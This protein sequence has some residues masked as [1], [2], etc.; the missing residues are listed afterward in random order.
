[1]PYKIDF[2]DGDALAWTL[3]DDGATV[4]RDPDWTPTFYVHHDDPAV[5]DEIRPHVAALPDVEL[6]IRERHRPGFRHEAEPVLRVD[7]ADLDALHARAHDVWGWREPGELTCWN[8]DFSPEFR[9]CL[10]TD[11]SPVPERDLRTLELERPDGP[12]A[13]TVDALRIGEAI[14]EGEAAVLDH[15]SRRLEREDPDVLFLGSASL[16]PRLYE[17]AQRHDRAAFDLGRGEGDDLPGYQQRAGRSTYESY[18]RTGHSPARYNVPGRVTINAGN[19]FFWDQTNLDGCLDLVERS[20]KPLQELAWA[21]IG[22]VLTAIQ[23][24]EARERDVLVP[25]HSWRHEFFKSARTLHDA[26]RG[27][28]TFAPD[29]GLHEHVHELDFSSLYPNIIVTRNISPETTRCGCCDS[30][31][32]PG[33][34][35]SICEERGYLADVL[36]PI[37]EDRDCIKQELRACDD[38]EH[39]EVLEGRSSALKWILVSCFGYQGFSNAKFG[40]IEC[41][42]SINAFARELL[43]DA[44]ERL[45]QGGWRVVHGI[46]DS[47]WVTPMA[48]R[49]QADL[50][51]LAAAITDDLGIDLEYEAGYDWL[52]FVPRRNDEAGALTKYFGRKRDEDLGAGVDPYKLRGIEARQRSTAPLVEEVQRELIEVLDEK[53]RPEAVCDRLRRWLGRVRRGSVAASDLVLTQRVSKPLEQYQSRTRTVAALQRAERRGLSVPPG[54]SVSYVVADDSKRSHERLR[55]AFEVDEGTPYDQRFYRD[56][57]LRAAESVL[58]PLGWRRADIESYLDDGK[59]VALGAFG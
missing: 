38:P 52:A 3:T 41:H 56:R 33:L 32:V 31:D 9:Y 10:E 21:S 40:R 19:T 50:D 13:P 22:N 5:L 34:G 7:T 28:F 23:I 55:L 42:E 4:E 2:V 24:R 53:R 11:R 15:L 48:D 25:W 14:V 6:T 47:L 59:D 17:A 51:G 44:K 29:V 45:E 46:V 8:V 26:D 35:Y 12:D 18:G 57:L 30:E 49:E 54:E 43:L 37:I 39:R 36:E 58:S 1:M 27:G 20:R 16:V